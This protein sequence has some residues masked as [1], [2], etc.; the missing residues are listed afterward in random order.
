MIMILAEFVTIFTSVAL[1]MQISSGNWFLA[2]ADAVIL[3]G[4]LFVKWVGE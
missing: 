1:G 3:A 4:T 2:G